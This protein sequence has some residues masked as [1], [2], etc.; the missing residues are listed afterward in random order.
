MIP[1]MVFADFGCAHHHDDYAHHPEPKDPIFLNAQL[2]DGFKAHLTPPPKMDSEAQ[3]KDEKVLFQRQK[4]RT[5]VVCEQAKNEVM[6]TLQSFYEEPKGPL[7]KADVEKLSEFFDQVK[8]DS[9]YFVQK[10]KKE[11]NRQ[12]PFLY[13]IGLIPC[14]PK[15]SSAAYP[16]GHATVAH[17]TALIWSELYPKQKSKF[18]ARADEIAQDRVWAGVHHPSDIAAGKEMAGLIF[19]EFKKSPS[20]QAA[21]ANAKTLL[22]KK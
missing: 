18:E 2:Y 17:L 9:A 10:L 6:V 11:Y 13:M 8:N 4:D 3:K 21:L 16:S 20:F 15:E 19:A 22:G 7:G 5:D 12:R 14:T 1:F